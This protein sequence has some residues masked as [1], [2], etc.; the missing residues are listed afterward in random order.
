MTDAPL[1]VVSGPS[2]V[3]KSTVVAQALRIDPS[4]WLSVVPPPAAPGPARSTAVT[5]SSSPTADSTS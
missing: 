5:T 2:G 3:G 1:V 4:I